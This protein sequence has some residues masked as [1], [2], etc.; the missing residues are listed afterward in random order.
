MKRIWSSL[1][2]GGVLILSACGNEAVETDGDPTPVKETSDQQPTQDELNEQLKKEAKTYSFAEI[3]ANEVQKNSKIIVEGAITGGS[4]GIGD[5]F[6]IES[7]DGVYDVVNFNTTDTTFTTNDYVKIYGAYNGKDE[8]TDIPIITSTIV[9]VIKNEDKATKEENK[10]LSKVGDQIYDEGVGNVKL[11]KLVNI[12]KEYETAGLKIKLLDAKVLTITEIEQEYMDNTGITDDQ[13]TYLQL[14][15][16]LENTTEE[17]VIF[18]GIETA[19]PN[20]G[21][22][23]DIMSEDLF[24]YQNPTSSEIRSKASVDQNILGIPV[25]KNIESIRLVPSDVLYD[26]EDHSIFYPEEILIEFK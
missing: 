6:Y 4:F 7:N 22:Q 2:L 21:K 9:E 20:D 10:T 23:I 25:E 3:N 19:I 18:N 17:T 14:R 11:E 13:I 1:I 12:N 16:D 8:T 15:Y 24:F 5:K 26:D